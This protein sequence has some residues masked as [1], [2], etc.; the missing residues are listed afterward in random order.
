M[1]GPRV[2]SVVAKKV[3]AKATARNKIERRL[4]EIVRGKNLDTRCA[5]VFHAKKGVSSTE[6][7]EVEK[8]I[9]KLLGK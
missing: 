3:V 5:Y 7:I 4:R 1:S 6:F 8:D 2:A 9:K